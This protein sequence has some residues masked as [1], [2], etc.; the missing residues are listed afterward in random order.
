MKER[1]Q[2]IVKR[3]FEVLS[4]S[5]KI[6]TER[7]AKIVYRDFPQYR[8]LGLA[9]IEELV[10][11]AVYSQQS[12]IQAKTWIFLYRQ[13]DSIEFVAYQESGTQLSIG[14]SWGFNGYGYGYGCGAGWLAGC[15]AEIFF[16]FLLQTLNIFV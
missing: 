2:A 4:R 6:T 1:H 14:F 7:L 11:V 12:K 8:D 16:I 10:T 3:L 5:E 13:L 15:G 9:K